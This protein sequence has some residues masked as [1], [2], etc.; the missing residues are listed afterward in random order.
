MAILFSNKSPDLWHQP[1]KHL[2]KHG[3]TNWHQV[4]DTLPSLQYF[5][6][7]MF[8]KQKTPHFFVLKEHKVGGFFFPRSCRL[9]FWT[10]VN[11]MQKVFNII[12]HS[13]RNPENNKDQ[14]IGW[15][16][17]VIFL[18]SYCCIS[19]VNIFIF[20]CFSFFIP[21]IDVNTMLI[22]QIDGWNMI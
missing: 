15:G 21:K 10:S 3:R 1:V 4:W 19:R 5:V 14:Y 17:G 22:M 9:A 12:P 11:F 18:I 6:A 8:L 16:P 13:P 7:E 20:P 2:R